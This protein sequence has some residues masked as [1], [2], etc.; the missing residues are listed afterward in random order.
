MINRSYT[1]DGEQTNSHVSGVRSMLATLGFLTKGILEK[2]MYLM[3]LLIMSIFA[4]VGKSGW[5][6]N[7]STIKFPTR[8][9]YGREIDCIL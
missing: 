5:V 8:K 4:L 2:D 9:S 6:I 3:G 7:E 1:C